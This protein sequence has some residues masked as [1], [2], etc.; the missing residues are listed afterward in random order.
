MKRILQKSYNMSGMLRTKYFFLTYHKTVSKRPIH[1]IEWF[2]KFNT[3]LFKSSCL[4]YLC[5]RIQ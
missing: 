3:G 4:E 5:S 2:P 1:C